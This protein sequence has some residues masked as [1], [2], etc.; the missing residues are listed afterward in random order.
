MDLGL[1]GKIV[2]ITGGSKGIGFACATAFAAEGSRI[3]ICSRS[4]ENI[5]RALSNLPKAIGFAV[6]LR[7]AQAASALIETVEASLGPVD[8][9]VNSAGAA[10]QAPLD[11]LRRMGVDYAQ[12]YWIGRPAP[13]AQLWTSPMRRIG[14]QH[15]R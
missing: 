6:D 2:L 11:E 8:V 14:G 4:Q 10:R 13:L 1:E 9:L 12:G 3:A 15:V 5:D 7:D